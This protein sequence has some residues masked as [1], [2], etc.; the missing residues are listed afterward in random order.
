[1][2]LCT[3]SFTRLVAGRERKR[4]CTAILLPLNDDLLTILIDIPPSDTQLIFSPLFE[5]IKTVTFV[6]TSA[7][8]ITRITRVITA[9][10]ASLLD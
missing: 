10:T 3:L 2:L 5:T 4:S 1:M 8:R 6:R 7:P 9:L